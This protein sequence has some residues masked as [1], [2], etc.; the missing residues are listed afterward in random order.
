MVRKLGP[1]TLLQLVKIDFQWFDVCGGLCG[2]LQVRDGLYS[3]FHLCVRVRLTI[4]NTNSQ[5]KYAKNAPNQADNFEIFRWCYW[6][7]IR[8]VRLTSWFINNAIWLGLF[9]FQKFQTLFMLFYRTK[10]QLLFLGANI[11]PLSMPIK[12]TKKYY[13]S[14]VNITIF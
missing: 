13:V 11:T 12:T 4:L 14:V 7:K 3:H 6:L 9:F 10:A 2:L 8:N 1:S 5:K